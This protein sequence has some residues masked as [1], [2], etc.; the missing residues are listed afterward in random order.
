MLIY[1]L[2]KLWI[3]ADTG[4]H[5]Y[6]AYDWGWWSSDPSMPE[7]SGP[8]P[9]LY[10]MADGIVVTI[11]NSH[12]DE[13]DMEGYGNYIVIRYPNEGYVSLYAHIKKSSFLVKVGD[14]VTQGQPVCR[15]GNSGYSFGNHLHL[16]V[17]KGT[18]FVRHGG[19]DYVKNKIV[20][21]TNWHVIDSDTLKDYGIVKMVIE[22]VDKDITKNQVNVTG[23]DLRIRETPATGKVVGFASK[24]YYNYTE[25]QEKD[26][27]TW[28]KVDN[29]WLAGNTDVSEICEATFVP[30]VADK[31]VNQA[32][33]LVDDDLRIRQEPST[34]ATILGYAPKGYYNVEESSKQSD[35]VWFKVCGAW[36]ACTDDVV[37]HAA[38]EDKDAEIRELKVE[39]EKLKLEIFDK[40]MKITELTD[41]IGKQDEAFASIKMICEKILV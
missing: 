37:Y 3:S 35:F 11:V 24:G 8:N 6:N 29:Y 10:A 2:R 33:V 4:D 36:I 19:V 7:D 12:P 41:T 39:I 38:E 13:P 28:C 30:T 23:T 26:G 32:E 27:Y 25:T 40:D 14:K 31:K 15:M 21:A 5:G 9:R 16:E 18:T 22:P 1:P 17:C 20:Y 34:T